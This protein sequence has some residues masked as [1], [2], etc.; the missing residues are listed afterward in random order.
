MDQGVPLGMTGSFEKY[1]IL[2]IPAID[3]IKPSLMNIVSVF[4]GTALPEKWRAIPVRQVLATLST[5]IIE[6]ASNPGL[7]RILR[8]CHIT[9]WR[10]EARF[11]GSCGAEN[12]DALAAE[13]TDAHRRC[14]K[15]G[16]TEYP[17]ICPAV[18][19][20]ITDDEDRILLAHNRK[21]RNR[22]YSHISGFNEA[23]ETLEAT[24]EREVREEVNIEVK[25]ITYIKS[26]AWPFPNSLM[27]GFRAH[28]SS[29]TVRP[30]GAEIEDAKWFTRNDLPE[31]PGEGSLSRFLINR[32]LAGNSYE[33]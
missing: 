8:A 29:G 3:K 6:S 18:I 27:V 20:L 2:E 9:Q 19:V 25:D 10:H 15:C 32:W 13:K 23:G 21:F 17:R 5:S 28:Y 14:S 22:V 7:S 24:V 16:R 4:P 12:I 30:D 33:T 31:L 11:C 26:Q 1:E